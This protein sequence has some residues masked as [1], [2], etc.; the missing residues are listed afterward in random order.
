MRPIDVPL[1]EAARRSVVYRVI[2]HRLIVGF[3]IYDVGL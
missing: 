3:R 1:H 2:L